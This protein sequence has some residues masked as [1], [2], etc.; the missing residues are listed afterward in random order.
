M[1]NLIINYLTLILIVLVFPLFIIHYLTTDAIINI[2]TYIGLSLIIPA[3]ILFTIARVQ[4]G[5]SF[6]VSAEANMLVTNGIYKKFRHPIYYFGL[7]FIL[8][9]IILFQVFY[10]IIIWCVMIFLQT[11]RI[12][13]EERV[14]E[15]KF[16]EQYLEYKKNTWF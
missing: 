2:Y 15:E 1:K 4:L 3:L 16:G 9:T 12:K 14:L 7:L 5:R 11:K 13:N 10:F 6:Q 8:G